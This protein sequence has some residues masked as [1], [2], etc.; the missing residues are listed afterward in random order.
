VVRQLG[1][2][3]L[4]DAAV[5][6]VAARPVVGREATTLV[7]IVGHVGRVG[8]APAVTL[9]ARAVVMPVVVMPVAVVVRGA[10]EPMAARMVVVPVTGA[11]VSIVVAAR[12][13]VV[14]DEQIVVG[15]PRAQGGAA[16]VLEAVFAVVPDP[17][18]DRDVL[19][20][21]A[22]PT[23]H[24]GPMERN[25]AAP[26]AVVPVVEDARQVADVVALGDHQAM[27]VVVIVA[28]AV[29]AM[30]GG[31]VATVE[32][33]RGHRV[34]NRARQRSVVRR[35]CVHAAAGCVNHKTSPG[36]PSRSAGRT[37]ARSTRSG[38]TMR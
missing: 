19:M 26:A 31:V 22:V 25:R 13:R 35:R 4:A 32:M 28:Q 8:R 9:V 14:A 6:V 38:G 23:G 10:E 20:A 17:R 30:Q 15:A 33:Q 24:D 12:P 21:H 27:P 2:V 1:V 36:P 11:M 37:S 5:L 29:A 7:V 34:R 16:V 18:R 3:V